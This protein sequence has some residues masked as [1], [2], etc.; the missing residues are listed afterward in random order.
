CRPTRHGGGHDRFPDVVLGVWNHFVSSVVKRLQDHLDAQLLVAAV[1]FWKAVVVADQNATR[2]ALDAKRNES[3]AGRVMSQVHRRS[4]RRWI[5]RQ[6]EEAAT[7]A[8]AIGPC[9]STRSCSV[10]GT[11]LPRFAPAGVVPL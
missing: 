2:N 4:L 5:L 10:R 3:V 7:G 8:A 1:Q 9:G 11:R 6:I